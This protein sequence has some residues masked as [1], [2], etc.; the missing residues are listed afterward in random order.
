MDL[1]QVGWYLETRDDEGESSVATLLHDFLEISGD[2]KR[3]G[4]GLD[5]VGGFYDE[6]C[7]S[8]VGVG[9]TH[10]CPHFP[11]LLEDRLAI[12]FVDFGVQKLVQ[13]GRGHSL[14]RVTSQKR[15]SLLPQDFLHLSL[16]L[17]HPPF[18]SVVSD[19]PQD[20]LRT[21]FQ[22]ALHVHTRRLQSV[23]QYLVRHQ[24]SLADL[25]LLALLV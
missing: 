12:L 20:R 21:Q 24:V 16:Q 10:G 5:G 14:H 1:D 18:S 13:V 22:F 23:H 4:F 8:V 19:D 9:Q 6:E 7:A 11:R 25:Q 15:K 3:V 17:P 2:E